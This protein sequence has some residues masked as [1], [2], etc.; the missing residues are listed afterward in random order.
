M[1]HTARVRRRLARSASILALL[2]AC[3]SGDPSRTSASAS[4]P[5]AEPNSSSSGDGIPIT[6]GEVTLTTA[7]DTTGPGM[8]LDLPTPVEAEAA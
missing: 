6:T 7:V 4:S 1:R 3:A 2:T 8:K 5:T